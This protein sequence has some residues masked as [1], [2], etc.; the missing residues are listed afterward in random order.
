MIRGAPS[1]SIAKTIDHT[2]LRHALMYRVFDA[3]LGRP[4]RDWSADMRAL[5]AGLAKEAEANQL[6]REMQAD[7]VQ[8]MLRRIQA[9]RAASEEAN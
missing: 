7:A 4:A 8:Q 6:F 9:I 2:E 5:Y 3:Y 1:S